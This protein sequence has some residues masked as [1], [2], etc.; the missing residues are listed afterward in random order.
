MISR[1][2]KGGHVELEP[3][4]NESMR[5]KSGH[6]EMEPVLRC[7]FKKRGGGENID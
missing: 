4:L 2:K 1:V 6:V 5:I 7:V 3:V